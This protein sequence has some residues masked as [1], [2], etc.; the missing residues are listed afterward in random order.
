M[1]GAAA[2]AIGS[3]VS[4]MVGPIVGLVGSIYGANKNYNA[5]IKTNEANQ[6]IN[7]SQL[8]YAR[9]MTQAQWERDDS[10]HQREV[11]DLK[12]AGLSPLA[13]L[14]GEMNTP[15]QSAPSMLAMQAPQVDMNA[16]IQSALAASQLAETTRHNKATEEYN[17]GKLE[18]ESKEL[19][20][21]AQSLD[22]ENKKVEETIKQNAKLIKLQNDELDEKIRATKKGEELRLSE[23]EQR[24][25]EEESTRLYKE[26]AR[27]AGGDNVNHVVIND[28]NIYANRLKLWTIQFN[29]FIETI[30]ATQSAS[31]KSNTGNGSVGVN[32]LKA[33]G[34]VSAGGSHSEYSSENISKKQ[35][36]MLRAFY[37]NHPIPVYISKSDYPMYYKKH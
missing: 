1:S 16:F 37:A 9:S 36:E 25:L 8:D 31:G 13:A 14:G 18:N 17:S 15:A 10:A 27:Q 35:E 20:L 5:T 29:K 26:I 2:A 23:L 19:E 12:A 24:Q 21:R 6:A 7:Q 22:I 28:Y 34:N 3:A 11:A 33:G 4:N 32:V 30:G